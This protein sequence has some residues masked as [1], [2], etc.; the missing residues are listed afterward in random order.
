M[1]KFL[2]ILFCLVFCGCAHKFVMPEN[3]E[4]K[5]VQNSKFNLATWQKIS[6]QNQPIHIYV[7]GDGHAFYANGAPTADPTPRDSFVR[8]LV[9]NDSYKNVAYIARPCQFINDSNCD[10]SAWT[11]A[12]FSTDA[13]DSL[14]N[15]IKQIAGTQP[16]ILI[17]YSGGALATGLVIK[18]HPEINIKKWITIAGVLNH[19]DWTTYFGD[20]DLD[21]SQDM[22][23]LPNV[24]QVHYVG[25]KDKIVP[26]TLSQKWIAPKNMKIIPG[27]TH[28]NFPNLN[29]DF[30]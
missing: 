30:E 6:N 9:V 1:K 22:S 27:A 10:M 15:T 5:P 3:Y 16:V 17:G 12:R 13:I 19:H 28:N 11:N 29:I 2:F 25:D 24:P 23:S 21:K 7:E 18:Q 20:A 4:F 8:N 26:I 14:A